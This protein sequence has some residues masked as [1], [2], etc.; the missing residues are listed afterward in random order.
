M[1]FI[2]KENRTLAFFKLT[3]TVDHL[4]KSP[5]PFLLPHG[6]P[7]FCFVLFVCESTIFCKAMS[8]RWS[9]SSSPEVPRNKC[10][11]SI[12]SYRSPSYQYLGHTCAWDTVLANKG[13]GRCEVSLLGKN[14]F[15]R[16]KNFLSCWALFCLHVMP[17]TVGAILQPQKT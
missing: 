13:V 11:C 14:L 9:R 6:N 2:R 4:P 12:W 5:I 15:K 7:G 17:T 8:F 16:R 1:V 10:D 3:W